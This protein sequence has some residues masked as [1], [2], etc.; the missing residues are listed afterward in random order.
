MCRRTGGCMRL[1]QR[2]PGSGDRDESGWG[3]RASREGR[4]GG[5]SLRSG[6][7]RDAASHFMHT[8][9]CTP[10]RGMEPHRCWHGRGHRGRRRCEE[11]SCLW[12]IRRTCTLAQRCKWPDRLW[13]GEVITRPCIAQSR[14]HVPSAKVCQESQQHAPELS[15]VYCTHISLTGPTAPYSFCLRRQTSSQRSSWSRSHT[16]LNAQP[17]HSAA[18]THP[19]TAQST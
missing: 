3:L 12:A 14:F 8:T 13:E 9:G 11:R 5:A 19:F 4:A 17:F 15:A 1:R 7:T 16:N 18:G 2:G 10:A 6:C